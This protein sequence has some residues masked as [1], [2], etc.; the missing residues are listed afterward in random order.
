MSSS[1][2]V[3]LVV[4]L[5]VLAANL[6]FINERCFALFAVQRFSL[7]KPFWLRIVEIIVLYVF[8]GELGFALERNAGNAFPQR[9]EFY[10]I[11]FCLFVVL[12][13][14]GFVY[15]YLRRDHV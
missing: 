3:W 4:V 15:R 1:A 14:P 5:A 7:A 11:S 6:P 10:A 12:G 9:W 13:F 8:V 2:S